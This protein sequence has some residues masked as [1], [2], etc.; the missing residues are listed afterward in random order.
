MPIELGLVHFQHGAALVTD[1]GIVDED[2][3]A[4]ER[5]DRRLDRRV[6][7]VSARDVT[8]DRNGR[9]ADRSCCLPRGGFVDV[10]ERNARALPGKEFGNALAKAR[11]PAGDERNPVVETHGV[12]PGIYVPWAVIP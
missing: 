12:L 5:I 6:H 9:V 1:P 2:V 7:I 10:G 8:N 4:A 3:N 11:G